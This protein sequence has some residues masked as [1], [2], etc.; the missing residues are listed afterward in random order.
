[1]SVTISAMK[2]SETKFWVICREDNQLTQNLVREISYWQIPGLR[3]RLGHQMS[4]SAAAAIAQADYAIFVTLS[5]NPR[6]HI[7][8]HPV[9]SAPTEDV[10]NPASFLK[11]LRQRHARAPQSWWLELPTTEVRHQGVKPIPVEQTL[12]QAIAQIEVFV[13]NYYLQPQLQ[14]NAFA[15]QLASMPAASRQPE[16]I[17]EEKLLQAA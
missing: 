15:H 17:Q 8:L 10:N 9:S 2:P 5:E 6:S 1:M 4:L 3:A 14:Q 12:S 7:Q 11:T 16:K 13:R